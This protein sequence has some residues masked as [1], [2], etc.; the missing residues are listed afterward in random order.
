ME[1]RFS[2]KDLFIFLM[3]FVIAALVV[4]GMVQFDR[5]LDRVKQLQSSISG[6]TNDLT[7][8]RMQLAN[9]VVVGNPNSSTSHPTT[10]SSTD[11]LAGLDPFY[12]LREAK[13]KP[14]YADG[15]W[16]VE[17][18][19]TSVGKLTP[20][21]STDVY[22]TWVQ[23]KV[24]ESLAYR[25]A[26]TLEYR[27]LLATN[28]EV[29]PDGK[30]M[31]FD[32]RKNVVFSDGKPLTAA[33][34]VFTVD[35]IM[36]PKID[37]PRDRAYL[38]LLKSWKADGDYRITFVWKE[39]VFNAF[40]TVASLLIMPKHFYEQ[41]SSEQYNELPGLLMGSGPYRLASPTD[42]RP[43]SGVQL[44]RNDRYWG[45]RPAFNK[46]VYFEVKDDVAE[47]T[48][49]RNR[50][51][52]RI[53]PPPD[54]FEKLR[55]DPSITNRSQ[56]LQYYSPI[57]GYTYIGWN[58]RR[59]Q[60]DT[61]KETLFADKRVRQAMTMLI[62]RDQIARDLYYGHAQ[63][64]TGP[65]GYG[66]PQTDPNI[67]P[68][69]YD[70]KRAIELLAEAGFTSKRADGILTKADGTPFEF[71]L[72]YNSG[73]AFTD[74]IVLFLKDSFAR[75]GVKMDLDAIDWPILLERLDRRDFDACTLGWTTG[76]ETDCNQIF[77]SDQTKDGGDNFVNY[78]S[79]EA[80]AAIEKARATVDDDERMK[81]WQAVHRI[82]HEDQPYTFLLIREGTGFM[83]S[84]I[85][86][87]HRTKLGL[88]MVLTGQMPIPWYVPKNEQLYKTD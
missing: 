38:S 32:L 19:G 51:L 61:W 41:F 88:N 78:V 36:N 5:Q 50:E 54:S 53:A 81:A 4:M 6:L 69:P 77:H 48:M 87:V 83:D 57:S 59:K 58:E 82:I 55:N 7:G 79:K 71:K 25:D 8:I 74:R 45:E 35:F 47:E 34:I 17:N 2:I 29:S 26:E 18:F 44:V 76:I 12:A 63:P 52:D 65:F 15:D 49:Y 23:V 24:M 39:F 56:I 3:L 10:N 27:P 37:A 22:A 1:N 73:N 85:K 33:D 9:G 60:G 42:W 14:D 66:S 40:E 62:D 86:N 31:T 21:I 64:A 16:L 43:G 84:R 75:A 11:G 28:W 20:L 80:D 13:A 68:W 72:S 67:K 30:T 70:P 46:L